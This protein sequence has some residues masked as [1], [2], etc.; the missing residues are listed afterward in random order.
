MNYQD[1]RE[2]LK[3]YEWLTDAIADGKAAVRK[4]TWRSGRVLYETSTAFAVTRIRFNG[5]VFYP[6]ESIMFPLSRRLN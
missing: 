1:E 3:D 4:E 6:G 5:T 2:K